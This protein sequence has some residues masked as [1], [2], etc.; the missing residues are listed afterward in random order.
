MKATENKTRG[1]AG[2]VPIAPRPSNLAAALERPRGQI[3]SRGN[4]VTSV[5]VSMSAASAAVTDMMISSG[6]RSGYYPLGSSSMSSPL[7][8][9]STSMGGISVSM[10]MVNPYGE[11]SSL[12]EGSSFMDHF[13]YL[14]DM[15]ILPPDG[16]SGEDWSNYSNYYWS[17]DDVP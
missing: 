11:G 16:P 15:D 10:P 6:G 1:Q 5:S 17:P 13:G 4:P 2:F 7:T 8:V 14:E 12:L 3:P 9:S